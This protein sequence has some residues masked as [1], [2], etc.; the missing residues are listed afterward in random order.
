MKKL[1]Y[2]IRNIP[3]SVDQVI[4]KRSQRSGKS[5]NAT[6]VEALTLQTLGR[7]DIEKAEQDIFTRIRGANS[8]DGDFDE[9]I[10]EQSVA[11]KKLWP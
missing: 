9:A 3:S 6:V 5:F 11:D 4:R 10:K 2:T 1:Q 7:L 8:L